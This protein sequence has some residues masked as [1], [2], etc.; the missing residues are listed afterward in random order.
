MPASQG[1]HWIAAGIEFE[2]YGMICGNLAASV[3]FGN[4]LRADITGKA[5]LDLSLDRMKDTR[6]GHGDKDSLSPVLAHAVLLIQASF[7]PECG[8]ISV[9]AVLGGESYLLA[10]DCHITG[11]FAFYLWYDGEH[12]GDFAITLGGYHREYRKPEHYP[13]VPQLGIRWQ[14]T[15]ELLFQGNLYFALTPSCLMAGGSLQMLFNAG[16]VQAWCTAKVDIFLQWNPFCYDFTMD[17]SL[18]VRVKIGFIK[19]KAEI[20][21][22]LH[23]WG[24]EFSGIARIKLWII[25][26]DI[27]FIKNTP[28]SIKKIGWDAFKETYLKQTNLKKTADAG[29]RGCD[30]R[31]YGGILQEEASVCR[32]SA[33]EFKVRIGAAVP[34]TEYQ[35]NGGKRIAPHC[36]PSLGIYPCGAEKAEVSFVIEVVSVSLSSPGRKVYADL[37]AFSVWEDTAQVPCALWGNKT[38]QDARGRWMRESILATV[39]I[40]LEVRNAGYRSLEVPLSSEMKVSGIREPI[41]VPVIPGQKYAQTE[42]YDRMAQIRKEP[43]RNVQKSILEEMGFDGD[44]CFQDGW[45]DSERLKELFREPPR[46]ETLGGGRL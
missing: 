33:G 22:G 31:I 27:K 12:K 7:R 40:A 1:Q 30:I 6:G 41:R 15:D 20:G 38:C 32:I 24:P 34:F 18:G 11:G 21:C 17:V 44:I 5:V 28:G 2:C 23:L 10:R 26:F 46:L 14:I 16:C 36:C 37:G 3:I 35:L 45:D 42:V 8:L 4:T 13:S 25:S 29:F 39:G 9:S 19:V 43:V